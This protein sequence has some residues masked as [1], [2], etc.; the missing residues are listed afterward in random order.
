MGTSPQ[1]T[2]DS[3]GRKTVAEPCLEPCP[4]E[5][6]MRVLGGKWKGSILWHLKDEPVRFNDLAR[7]MGGASK[8]MVSQRLQEMEETGLVKREVICDRPIA[9]TYEITEFGKT[10]LSVLEELKTWAEQHQI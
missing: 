1:I 2:T 9:V 6:G 10:A 4:I 5:R 7:Q 8:K 3:N